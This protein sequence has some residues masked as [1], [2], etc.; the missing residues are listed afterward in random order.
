M[1]KRTEN[2]SNEDKKRQVISVTKEA[3]QILAINFSNYEL[4][5]VEVY[6]YLRTLNKIDGKFDE[7]IRNIKRKAKATLN[8]NGARQK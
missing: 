7:G 5:Q 2:K 8:I 3:G 4:D 1:G 6:E